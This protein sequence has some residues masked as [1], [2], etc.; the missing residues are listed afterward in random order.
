LPSTALIDHLSPL[1]PVCL[2]EWDLGQI[3]LSKIGGWTSKFRALPDRALK[4]EI[5]FLVGRFLALKQVHRL[6]HDLTRIE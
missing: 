1:A 6:I 5:D 4:M 2:A 3:A